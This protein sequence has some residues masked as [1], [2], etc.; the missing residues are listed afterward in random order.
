MARQR[1]EFLRRRI[2]EHDRRYYL[3][4]APSVS[5]REYDR[6]MR[7]L[8]DLEAEHPELA[9]A[10]SP[11]RRIG[12]MPARGFNPARH[13]LPMLSLDNTYSLDE[14]RD[15]DRSLGRLL[16]GRQWTYMVE[17]KV[18]G[19]AFCLHYRQGSL[20]LAATR[21]NGEVGDDI[22]ANVRTIRSIPLT[23]PETAPHIELRGEVYMPRTA[24]AELARQQAET[25]REPFKNARNA[26]AG[27]LKLLDSK[28]VAAR[29]LDA[30][31]YAAGVLEGVDFATQ[32]ELLKQLDLW[33][34]RTAPWRRRCHDIEEV[35]AAVGALQEARDHLPFDTD[36][37][38]VKVNERQFYRLLGNTARS[39]RWAK[40]FKFAAEQAVTILRAITVQVG[41]TGVLTPVAELRTVRLAG[42]DISRATL[43][44]ADEIK[45]KDIRVGD[46][47][48]VE[49]A[50]EVIPAVV[51][52]QAE[53]R[54]GDPPLFVMP[55]K[56]PVCGDPVTRLPGEVAHRCLSPA[57]PA[58]LT[59]RLEHMAA[60]DALDIEG[61]GGRVAEALV[62]QGW[63]RQP[64]DVFELTADRLAGLNLGR[65][66]G[67][68]VLGHSVA[69]RIV[70]ALQRSRDY[71][72]DRWLLALGIPG[73]GE[74]IAVQVASAHSTLAEVADSPVLQA[75]VRLHAALQELPRG[76][77]RRRPILSGA[78]S[79]RDQ[80]DGNR[81]PGREIESLGRFL[82]ER[83]Q[84]EARPDSGGVP[85]ITL[86]KPEAAR[87]II[88]FFASPRGRECLSRMEHLGIFPA[89]ESRPQ[90]DAGDTSPLAGKT[91]VV[92]G[93]FP[94]MSRGE[95]TRKLQEAGAR[96]TGQVSRNTD[97]LVAGDSPGGAKLNRARELG[98]A[99]IGW[100]DLWR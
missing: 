42:S 57:C 47:V 4:H 10:D 83:G 34:L 2:A 75:V 22:T 97:F 29:P 37:A 92:S 31:L 87:S 44:N 36:G 9:S 55:E 86:V 90:Q 70:A 50:G 11:T 73:V 91:V 14:L 8:A 28:L 35:V 96:V 26:A 49:K 62:E 40:A 80:A 81:D 99:V 43:H 58:Q 65:D 84:A 7:E 60:R 24:F 41:R 1:I 69:R 66:G 15:F 19:V 72:L 88:A 33:G 30:L 76:R 45:R 46:Y 85:F 38:V 67:R 71:P 20:V 21:G 51:A 5:D 17:P 6:L 89:G 25:G 12:D 64:L 63:V 74:T 77:A 39:P 52:V 56:C 95:A 53:M 59:G 54:Q 94:G 100:D 16:P 48:V 27:S 18:D 98:V 68:R 13:E 82:V 32:D 79:G 93:A 23:I 61:L 78:P 3:E